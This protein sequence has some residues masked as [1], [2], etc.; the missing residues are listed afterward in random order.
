MAALPTLGFAIAWQGGDLE[1]Y[2]P[3]YPFLFLAVAGLF[4]LERVPIVCRVLVI[5][6]FLAAAVSNMTRD[7][8][9]RSLARTAAI[10]G[11]RRGLAA[12]IEAK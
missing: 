10:D 3:L 12:V 1:R 9:A 5:V 8:T 11:P 7:G 6:F 2:L 4:A